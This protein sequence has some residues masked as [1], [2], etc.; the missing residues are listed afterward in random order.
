MK[1]PRRTSTKDQSVAKTLRLFEYIFCQ[2]IFLFKIVAYFLIYILREKIIVK[3]L[4]PGINSTKV[5]TSDFLTQFE[6][7]GLLAIEIV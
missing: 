3:L 7:E 1:T 2:T 6:I 4:K 5:M